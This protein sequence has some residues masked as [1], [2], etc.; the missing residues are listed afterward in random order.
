MKQSLFRRAALTFALIF[1]PFI[2]GLLITYEIIDVEWISFMENQDVIRPM[3]QPFAVPAD[4][5]PVQGAAF[6]GG[7]GSPGNP[8]E[9]DAVSIER[10][11]VLYDYNCRLCHGMEGKGDGPVAPHFNT[12]PPRNLLDGSVVSLS[13]GDIFLTIT[14]GKP[15]MP[16]LRENLFVMD[17][18]DVV[19]YVRTMQSASGD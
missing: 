10:G 12:V 5:V 18:W 7:I 19:N 1:I 3:E 17:R 8:V 14:N 6:V 16:A 9:S 2:I 11:R 13:D 4:A 15:Y